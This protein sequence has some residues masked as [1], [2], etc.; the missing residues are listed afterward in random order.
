M[1]AILQQRKNS[2]KFRRERESCF[3]CERTQ[4]EGLT[5]ELPV[6][7]QFTPTLGRLRDKTRSS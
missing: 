3:A 7:L 5:R 2:L 1:R 4:N 6:L